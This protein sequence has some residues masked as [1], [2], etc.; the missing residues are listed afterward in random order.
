MATDHL[1]VS[2]RNTFGSYYLER[3]ALHRTDRAYLDAVLT[4][5]QARV[6]AVSG[7]RTLFTADDQPYY[8]TPDALPP[9]V[10]AGDSAIYLAQV[11][12]LTYIAVALPD[13][14]DTF[15]L[16]DGGTAEFR[17]LR[18]MAPL[19][20]PKDASLLAYA[21]AM[22]HWQRTNRYC[23]TCGAPTRSESGGHV[24]Q[25]TS[26]DCGRHIFPR[27]DPA[28]IVLVTY[29]EQALLAR[30]PQSTNG[31]FSTLAGFVEPG[32]TLE[33][34]VVREVREEVGVTL[35]TVTYHSSQ[36]WPFPGSIMI[37]FT[38]EAAGQELVLEEAEIAEARW[39]TRPELIHA[40]ES[41]TLRFPSTFSIAYRLI[42]DWL[43][44]ETHEPQPAAAGRSR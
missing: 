16:P 31:V 9:S 39:F 6:I 21:R 41:G 27:T 8:L 7:D 17:D 4:G 10:L 42:H 13:S 25:C 44:V 20:Q 36:P 38:A 33:A 35:R 15:S 30:R 2:Q 43:G 40:F 23:G 11:D 32:E 22:I 18:A 37:G 12:G 34:A 26:P 14:L 3:E 24:R 1:S 5:G 29:G 19:L 28:I